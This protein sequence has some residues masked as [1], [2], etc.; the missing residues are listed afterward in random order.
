M[1][2]VEAKTRTPLLQKRKVYPVP[3]R[4]WWRISHTIPYLI[5]GFTFLFGSLC[6]FTTSTGIGL[7]GDYETGG[8]LFTIG[9]IGFLFADIFEWSTNNRVGCWDTSAERVE[10]EHRN[11]G[12]LTDGRTS[13]FKLVCCGPNQWMRAENG[14]NFAYSAL[15][16]LLYLIGSIMFIPSLDAIVFGTWVFIFGSFI[17]FSS[18]S[19]KLYRYDNFSDDVPAVNVDAW[20]GAGGLFY[21]IGSVQF[22]P[23][24]DLSDADTNAA[25]A[26]FT[27]GGASFT[28][29][30]LAIV[31]R[32]FIAHPP[33]Y[34][35]D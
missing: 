3:L 5:G 19:W 33:M 15:G 18:Q 2:A 22:L 14:I 31:Y 11:S 35:T 27:A 9:S 7:A 29:S 24:Y 20:A 26:W 32:Y 12:Y 23:A 30:G 4:V 17:I 16:S 10:W 25:A 28:I 21:L 1:A 8:W 34:E 13:L 6:Y